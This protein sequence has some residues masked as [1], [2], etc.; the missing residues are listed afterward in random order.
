[1]GKQN[2]FCMWVEQLTKKKQ[3]KKKKNKKK[4]P[5]FHKN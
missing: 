3:K 4:F 5:I 2:T 1:M